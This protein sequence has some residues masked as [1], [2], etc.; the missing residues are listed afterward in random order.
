MKLLC[1]ILFVFPLVLCVDRTNFKTCEQATFCTRHRKQEVRANYYV[2]PSTVKANETAIEAELASDVNRLRLAVALLEDT[3]LRISL[4]EAGDPLRPRYQP[5]IALKGEPKQKSLSGAEVGE[6]STSFTTKDGHKVVISHKPFRIDVFIKKE[7]LFS[8]NSRQLLKFEHFREKKEGETSEDGFWEETFKS[9][10]DSKPF[11]S[12]SIGMD[13]SF[14]GFKYLYGLPEHADSFALRSTTGAEPYRLYNLD[15]FE[16]ELSNTMALYGS[17]PYVVAHNKQ[18]TVGALWLNAAETWVDIQ[19][20]TADKGVLASIVDQFRSSNEVP[21]VST[22]FISESGTI[23]LFLLLGPKPKDVF[24]QY[25]A[26]T[27]VYPLPPIFS[28]AY[29][30]CRW[31]YNDEDDVAAV[32][33]GFDQHD[34]PLD[35]LWLDIEHTDGKKYFT[36][37]P[38]KF[39]NP[40]EMLQKVEE[41]GRRMVT[42]IDPH[43]KRDDNYHVFK[44]ASDNGYFIK[45][46]GDEADY[47][48]H[49]WPGASMYLDFINPTVRDF[50]ASKFTLDQYVGSTERLFTWNDMNEPSVFSGPETTMHKDA[51][52]FGGLEHRDVHNIYG[53][54]QHT[55]TYQGHLKRSQGR[56]RP[57]ILT[58]AF[59]VGSQRT[60][61]VWTGDNLA[62]WGH[63]RMSVPMLLSLSVAGIP[64]VGADVGGF[65]KNVDDQLIVRWYQA[66]A[67]QPFFRAH[68]HIDCK[69]REPWLY[70]DSS[71]LAIRKA[72]QQ[73]YAFLPYWYTLFYEHSKTGLPV[74]RPLWLEFPEDESGFDEEREWMVGSA[75][76][77]RPVME[78]DV[79][80]VSLYL[81]GRNQAWFE[82]DS[83]K[84]HASPGAVYIDTPI[85]KIPVYQRG[86]TIIPR[87]ERPRRSSAAMQNDPITLYVAAQ[88]EKDFANGSIYL[89]DGETFDYEKGQYLHWGFTYKK[90]SDFLYTITSKNL[91]PKGEYDPDVYIERIVIRGVRY[92]P[93]NIHLYYDDYNPENLEF[94]HDRD[95][96]LVVIRKPGA[97]VSREWRIDIH[98]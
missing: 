14:V 61:A 73:R 40:K 22:Q 15:V 69:R 39:A 60:T 76:L 17:V 55:S 53:F 66:G 65:F 51:R 38:V 92:F 26:L 90:E 7:L 5:L 47:E 84:M 52:H 54:L 81:P 67:Y 18:Y 13:I 29:H 95:L 93:R 71:K 88:L 78:P 2:D 11:G 4:T 37:D 24:R 97:Y 1:A 25:S 34:I 79:T 33:A 96:R 83:H 8:V 36:W 30:Q 85:D 58:R 46:A 35:A 64:H 62:D 45:S 87:R 70:T 49:C 43:I 23:D 86:G 21:E 82:W 41:K 10:R 50:W 72:I 57:F 68:A 44:E 63:L 56:L 59:F 27:G 42:I 3:S 9:H 91:D 6:T 12:S 31:N 94:T 28:V 74:M 89:D 19:S 77:V 48:G 16:Y 80:S 20:S 32:H 98:T 75:L